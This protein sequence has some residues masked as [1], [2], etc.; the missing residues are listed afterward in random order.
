MRVL[1]N[2]G[3]LSVIGDDDYHQLH[4]PLGVR[5]HKTSP[6]GF[7]LSSPRIELRNTRVTTVGKLTSNK[8]EE[9]I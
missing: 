3:T 2:E 9:A 7:P 8:V 5:D 6:C 1:Q 4:G